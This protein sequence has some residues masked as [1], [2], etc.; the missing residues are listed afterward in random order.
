MQISNWEDFKDANCF[1]CCIPPEP[2]TLWVDYQKYSCGYLGAAVVVGMPSPVAW[3]EAVRRFLYWLDGE[4]YDENIPAGPRR[5]WSRTVAPDGVQDISPWSASWDPPAGAT[6]TGSSVE[7]VSNRWEWAP[8]LANIKANFEG[9]YNWG[10]VPP[11]PTTENS[12]PSGVT[13]R[14]V[15]SGIYTNPPNYPSF[16]SETVTLEKYR[17]K[18][19]IVPYP[20]KYLKVTWDVVFEPLVGTP[21]WALQDQT[22]EWTGP[23]VMVSPNDPSWFSP[24]IEMPFPA[25]PGTMRI[26]N[27]RYQWYRSSDLGFKPHTIGQSYEI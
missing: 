9:T 12:T 16:Q 26:V 1:G 13:P 24:W 10:N 21:T 14:W 3:L 22:W 4:F 15:G 6:I 7:S 19:R 2:P 11:Q 18:W 23:G 25:E 27:V 8:F 20:G 5:D 17:F